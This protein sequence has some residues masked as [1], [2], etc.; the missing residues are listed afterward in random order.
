MYPAGNRTFSWP[1][2]SQESQHT[3]QIEFGAQKPTVIVV[4]GSLWVARTDHYRGNYKAHLNLLLTQ[5]NTAH[6]KARL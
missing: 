2:K 4:N 3:L 6:S 5:N 1:N